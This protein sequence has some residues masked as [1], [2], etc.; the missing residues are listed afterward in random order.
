MRHPPTDR[1]IGYDDTTLSHQVLDVSEA[2]CKAQIQ[3]DDMLDD[4]RWKPIT[5][6]AECSHS[7]TLPAVRCQRHG[8]SPYVTS[9][10]PGLQGTVDR[11]Q[12]GRSREPLL[13][14][15]PRR[16]E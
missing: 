7:W 5:S 13:R 11:G 10:T 12:S 3:P 14:R 4:C 8:T 6:V 2:E 15:P 1:L 9:P 16:R